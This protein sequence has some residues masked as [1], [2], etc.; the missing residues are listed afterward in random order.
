VNRYMI[1]LD[2]NSYLPKDAPTLLKRARELLRGNSRVII[3]DTRVLKKYIEFD[4]SIPDDASITDI[5]LGYQAIAPIAE[6]DL[7]IERILPKADAIIQSIKLFNDEKYW[8]AHEHLESIWK[9]SRGDEKNL[10]NGIILIAAAFVHDEKDESE[11]CISILSRALQ[12]LNHAHGKYLS[13]DID[14][15]KERISKIIESRHIE[16]FVI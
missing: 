12:K 10:L 15:I 13:I 6:Y 9:N 11:I 8:S 3:R 16:R 4:T 7:I 1:Y 5:L 14:K 2:N